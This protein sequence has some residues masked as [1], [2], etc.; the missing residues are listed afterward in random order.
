MSFHAISIQIRSFKSQIT[1]LNPS[2]EALPYSLLLNAFI[3][4]MMALWPSVFAV[5]FL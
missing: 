3:L 4:S 5:V 1:E 2:V